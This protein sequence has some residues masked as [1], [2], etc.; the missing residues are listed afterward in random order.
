M[1]RVW[2]LPED[3]I[4]DVDAMANRL[5]DKAFPHNGRL[6]YYSGPSRE[7]WGLIAGGFQEKNYPRGLIW[8]KEHGAMTIDDS[9]IGKF[10]NTYRKR[11]TF[12]YFKANPLFVTRGE[13]A[14]A[15]LL[16]WSHASRLLSLSAFGQV[17]TTVT[18]ASREGVYY[19]VEA[20]N[21][22]APT[23]HGLSATEFLAA[24]SSPRPKQVDAINLI[25]FGDIL[26]AYKSKDIEAAHTMIQLGEI[27]MALHEALETSKPDAI[28]TALKMASKEV[29]RSPAEAYKYFLESRERFLVD[30]ALQMPSTNASKQFMKKQ[31]P[32]VRGKHREEKLDQ[33]TS[34][35][36]LLI[37]TEIALMPPASR[38][39]F[40]VP[41]YV[42]TRAP[43]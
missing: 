42:K 16:P 2:V 11:G 22:L 36:L 20:P 41:A 14:A 37:E 18:G 35:V 19:T 43:R 5:K 40:I 6:H 23:Y 32:D 3:I 12:N 17:T 33:F 9:P 26:N 39:D 15:G 25:P 28:K 1:P 24:L 38:P 30:R 34:K 8:A 13:K 21:T 4:A 29:L 27:R 10:L 31:T 7:V